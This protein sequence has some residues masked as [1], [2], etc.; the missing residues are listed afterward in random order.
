MKLADQILS[1][2]NECLSPSKR[3]KLV[4]QEGK[5]DN[6]SNS[7]LLNHLSSLEFLLERG[8]GHQARLNR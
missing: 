2:V 7:E 4:K 6:I 1:K 5:S 3:L 8:L